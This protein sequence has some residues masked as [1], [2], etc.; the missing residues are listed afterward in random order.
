MSSPMAFADFAFVL[1]DPASGECLVCER[2]G[3]VAAIHAV[4]DG[5]V[6][7]ASELNVVG[8]CRRCSARFRRV[9]RALAI[10][11]LSVCVSWSVAA[12]AL[13]LVLSHPHGV[14][15]VLLYCHLG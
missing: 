12:P 5:S 13:G 3:R 7:S 9:R 11:G 8:V 14:A 15:R 1:E 2:C 6:A 10:T 4:S